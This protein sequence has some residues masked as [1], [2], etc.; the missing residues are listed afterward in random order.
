MSRTSPI[1]V[2]TNHP[3]LAIIQRLRKLTHLMDN[4]IAIPG[5]KFRIGLDPILGLIPGAGD[6]I[7]TALSAYI[8]LEAVR[9][10][11]PKETLGKMVSN[12]L[13]ESVVGTVP[14]V[15]DWFDFA[16]KANVKNLELI[17]THLGV[18]N[19]SKPA[20]R[21][22][23]FLLVVGFLIIGIGLVTFSVLVFKLLLNAVTS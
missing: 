17:E 6:F 19:I 16:W 18:T 20:N 13:L 10:G 11:L 7:G 23:M 1:P 15:G 2:V 9:L 12:I 3:R 5:T 22:L 21:W 8:V 14:I 4:A